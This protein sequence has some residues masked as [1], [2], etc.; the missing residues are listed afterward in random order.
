[1]NATH[2]TLPLTT[3][4]D[5][6][7]AR[8]GAARLA[9]EAGVERVERLE[10][11]SR[12]AA[13]MSEALN[14]GGAWR[15]DIGVI[16]E[17]VPRLCARIR[18]GGAPEADGAAA[19]GR[20]WEVSAAVAADT[21]PAL[22]PAVLADPAAADGD[23]GPPTGPIAAAVLDTDRDAGAVVEMLRGEQELVEWHRTELEE[24]NRGVLA[25]HAELDASNK[26]QQRLLE[27]EQAARN[28]LTFVSTASA[29]LGDS[30]NHEEVLRRFT[31]LLVPEHART[32]QVWLLDSEQRPTRAIGGDGDLDAD[33]LRA[34]TL[35][36]RTKHAQHAAPHPGGYDCLDDVITRADG[37]SSPEAAAAPQPA[38]PGEDGPAAG[39]VAEESAGGVDGAEGAE[40]PASAQGAERVE[41]AEG[42]EGAAQAEEAE[43]PASAQE[44]P[45]AEETEETAGLQGAEGSG[46]TAPRIAVPLIA[47]GATIGVLVLTPADPRPLYDDVVML[48]ELARRAAIAADNA[49]RYER[50][51]D[52]AETLQRA[53][54]TD[55]PTRADLR[56]AARYL[57]ATTGMN[58]GGDWYDVFLQPDDSLIGVIGDVTGHGIQAAVMMGQLRNA[59]RAY[60]IE[61]HRPGGLLT[62]L[63]NLLCHLEPDLFASAIIA[64]IQPGNPK[65][66]WSSAGH[67]PPLL[68][69]PD[70]TVHVLRPRLGAMLGLPID[71]TV[72]DH[73]LALP[74]GATLLLYTD[75]L[76]ERRSAGVDPGIDQL[77]DILS[78]LGPLLEHDTDAAADA[79]LDE[80]L[81]D[82]PGEDDVCLL[83]CH[84]DSSEES[85]RTDHPLAEG[86][87]VVMSR[88]R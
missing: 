18:P 20:V 74:P 31:E 71:Q 19:G 50:E 86:T 34:L 81:R 9:A 43:E 27:A 40:G 41:G 46:V 15:L 24:T 76:V 10:F 17:P 87:S 67:L 85:R 57:P 47:R 4:E 25:L 49:L 30:L 5:A 78:R 11:L 73:E 70:G 39:S 36:V 7:L 64:Q 22:D 33:G 35:A 63:H 45:R 79:I 52:I 6:A 82:Y 48:I 44:A 72:A 80:M 58:V 21:P 12:L 75:G 3:L 83:L 56:L 32:A 62:R 54:L 1:M 65:V 77:A 66:T 84:A 26:A 2:T 51:R 60:A 23:G 53:M 37:A 14:T 59:L 13:A 8:T 88:K 55:L 61:G 42:A 16:G 29:A 28:R 38:A 68:R 69:D